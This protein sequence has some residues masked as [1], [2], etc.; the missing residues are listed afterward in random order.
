M[1]KA[2]NTVARARRRG[3]SP[4]GGARGSVPKPP[5]AV[6]LRNHDA[7]EAHLG[8]PWNQL[9]R[10]TCSLVARCRSRRNLRLGKIA[11]GLLEEF[12]LLREIKIHNDLG[13]VR[14]S[15]KLGSL[16]YCLSRAF[17][18]LGGSEFTKLTISSRGAPGVKISLTPIFLRLWISS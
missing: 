10:K 11:D 4:A 15:A 1:A 16:I 8:H 7:K 6:F 14:L 9:R 13:S 3:T 17:L 18:F 2:Q 5:P 12:L